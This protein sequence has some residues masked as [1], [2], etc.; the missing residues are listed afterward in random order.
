MH[1][2]FPLIAVEVGFTQTLEDLFDCAERLFRGTYNQ[3]QF[4]IIVKI[5]E[6]NRHCGD[7]FPWG[8]NPHDLNTLRNMDKARALAPAIESWYDTNGLPIIGDL[9]VKVFWYPC[10][11]K[12]RPTIPLYSFK[13]DPQ[14]AFTLGA[15]S[16]IFKKGQGTLLN[17]EFKLVLKGQ[18]FSLPLGELENGLSES[19][20]KEKKARI[21]KM[22][23]KADI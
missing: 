21:S 7:Q 23:V 17:Q 20:N 15:F 6:T 13:H 19:I 12:T 16:Q 1:D 11:R 2:Q 22:I 14:R 5:F 8:I 18:T 10:G 4:V 9:E 3:I